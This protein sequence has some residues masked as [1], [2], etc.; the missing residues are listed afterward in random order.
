VKILFT[1]EDGW[2]RVAVELD[3][4]HAQGAHRQV[5]GFLREESLAAAS[6]PA[7]FPYRPTR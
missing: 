6:Q 1:T 5:E 4:L 2:K 7:P 3:P